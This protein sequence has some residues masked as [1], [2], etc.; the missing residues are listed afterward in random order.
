MTAVK[1][2]TAAEVATLRKM[3]DAGH[4]SH[5]I[6]AALSRRPFSVLR[7]AV[8]LG[9]VLRPRLPHASSRYEIRYDTSAEIFRAVQ[10]EAHRRGLGTP[11]RLMRATTFFWSKIICSVQCSTHRR[12]QVVA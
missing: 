9:I 3:A 5:S 7:K 11:A 2:F 1:P 4:G 6:A 12:R 8:R 10:A